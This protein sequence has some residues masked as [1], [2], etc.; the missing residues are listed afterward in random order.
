MNAYRLTKDAEQDLLEVARYTLKNWG[1]SLFEEYRVG[2]ESRFAELSES[3]RSFSKLFPELLVAKYRY[4]FIFY[5]LDDQSKPLI[6]GKKR[7]YCSI[8]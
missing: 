7:S 6:I 2:L 4:H 5:L 1:R 8:E 3:R